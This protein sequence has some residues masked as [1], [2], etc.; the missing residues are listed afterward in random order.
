[1]MLIRRS[2]RT[3]TGIALAAILSVACSV[4]GEEQ[5]AEAVTVSKTYNDAPFD[6]QS[7]LLAE[8]RPSAS[9]G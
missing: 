5:P 9:T 7:R 3:V 2:R 4:R 6:Y 1:M 8:R